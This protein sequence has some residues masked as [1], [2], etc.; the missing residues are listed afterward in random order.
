MKK[1]I[2]L[3]KKNKAMIATL[4]VG[5]LFSLVI[6]FMNQKDTK[7]LD[8]NT[9]IRNEWSQGEYKVVVEASNQE[10]KK[11]LELN[12]N[13]RQYTDGELSV[14]AVELSEI[15]KNKMLN[16]NISLLNITRDLNLPLKVNGYPFDIRWAS[17][18]EQIIN[19]TGKLLCK[20]G[21]A[22]T[23]EIEL[24]AVFICGRF[25]F[26]QI[27]PIRIVPVKYSEEEKLF[28]DLEEEINLSLDDETNKNIVLPSVINGHSLE[29]KEI[30]ANSSITMFLVTILLSV[31][32][33][34]AVSYDE[35]KKEKIVKEKMMEVYPAFVE[36]LK[37]YMISGLSLKNALIV[38][39]NNLSSLS[40]VKYKQLIQVL[41]EACNK[42]KNGVGEE[43]IVMDL[44]NRCGGSYKKLSFILSVNLKQGNDRIIGLLN[45]EVEN[46]MQKRR[47]NAK[48]KGDEASV[49]LL[50]PMILMMLIVMM[51]IIFPAYFN[52]E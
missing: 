43:R 34:M 51:L 19:N 40:S 5:T 49:K 10:E 16:G 25:R 31:I 1:K 20:K 39:K 22:D 45:D 38:M 6:Y 44:G 2:R 4:V 24:K 33:G 11:N 52:F 27:I 48:K 21:C 29:Y 50:F 8:G 9:I 46:A 41:N 7:L 23:H 15:I 42:Y 35:K 12:I 18:D 32:M 36:R 26:E 28:V 17:S 13:E 37:L 3:S 14:K 47:E 30:Q